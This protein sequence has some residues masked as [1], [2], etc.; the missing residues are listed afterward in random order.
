[1]HAHTHTH[2]LTH[3]HTHTHTCTCT[4]ARTHARTHTHTLPLSINR[5]ITHS[6][7][8]VIHI[9]LMIYDPGNVQHRRRVWAAID[10][11]NLLSKK[12]YAK[13]SSTQCKYLWFRWK[14][15]HTVVIMTSFFI[16][17]VTTQMNGIGRSASF[18]PRYKTYITMTID[19]KERTCK[20]VAN[21][22]THGP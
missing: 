4:H 19:A 13:V 17:N 18:P 15:F 10:Y 7:C 8:P 3:A 2:T 21:K 6:H 5:S 22:S 11:V 9:S 20:T 16:G 1:M 12:R 14:T